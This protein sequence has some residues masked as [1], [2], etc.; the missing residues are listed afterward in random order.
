MY[1]YSFK[2]DENMQKHIIDEIFKCYSVNAIEIQKEP[3]LI[4]AAEGVG[5][6][7][8]YSGEQFKTKKVLWEGGGG[9]MSIVAV[10][11]YEGYFFAS[12]GFYSMVDSETSAVYLIRYQQ[13]QFKE[14]KI[15]DIPYLHRFDVIE[16]ENCRYFIGCT[17]HSGKKDK[18]DWSHPGKIFIATLPKDLDQKID[19]ELS[20]LKE[21]LTKN[22]GFNRGR[23]KGQDVVFVASEEGVMA[24]MPPIKGENWATE[25]IFNHP[26]SD[27]A[28][29]DIDGDGELEFAL[30]SPF[31]GNQMH[32][33]KQGEQG[34]ESVYTYPI[35]MDF[36]HAIF[37]GQIHGKPAF[38]LGAR[39]DEQQLYMVQYH[40]EEG[41]K[42][43]LL[44]QH[45]GS[46]NVRI[47]HING[48]D[49]VM[50]ANRQIGEAAL[51]AM[52]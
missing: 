3:H 30:I 33:M 11:D 8:I 43:T 47:I 17:L 2:G 45:V 42:A 12:K 36:Y 18:E 39:K 22:H 27:V 19:V 44:D 23:W 34:Y 41:F 7:Q 32:I 14:E 20:V 52:N 10:P 15:F 38:V 35:T 6:C 37:A 24:V 46:S 5:S 21:G 51:Y 26:V 49:Y 9:T 25:Q 16:S 29:I 1:I 4:Y 40:Q 50:S 13:G 28:A 31:H 48:K